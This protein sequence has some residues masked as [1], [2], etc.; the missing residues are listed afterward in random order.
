MLLAATKK[1]IIESNQHKAGDTG[2]TEVQIALIS[3]RIK[4]LEGHFKANPKDVHSRRGLMRLV[5]QRR[6]LLAYLKRGSLSVYRALLEK[7]ELRG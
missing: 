7:L 4:D 5:S 2:S 6:S 1:K 3:A